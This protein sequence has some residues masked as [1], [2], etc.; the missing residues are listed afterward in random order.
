MGG[1]GGVNRQLLVIHTV[2]FY[3]I[4]IKNAC[5]TSLPFEPE[6]IAPFFSTWRANQLSDR[7]AKHYCCIIHKLTVYLQKCFVQRQQQLSVVVSS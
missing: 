5:G 6:P 1:G 3:G 2:L 4:R 7:S